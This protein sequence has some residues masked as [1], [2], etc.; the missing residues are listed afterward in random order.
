[1][2]LRT[3]VFPQVMSPKKI[4]FFALIGGLVVLL[5]IA[6]L[7]MGGGDKKPSADSESSGS[8]VKALQ[9]WLLTDETAGYSEIIKGFKN[10]FPQY[11]DTEIQFTKFSSEKEYEDI[12]IDTIANGNSPDVFMLRNNGGDAKFLTKTYEIP[13]SVINV[14]E[15]SKNFNKAFDGLVITEKT[16]DEDGN[17]VTAY[18]LKGVPMGYETLAL[19]YN[20][21]FIRDIPTLWSDLDTEIAANDSNEYAPVGLGLPSRYVPNADAIVEAILLQNNIS[22]YTKLSETAAAAAV[23]GYASF[24]QDAK[25]PVKALEPKM[26]SLF[27]DSVDLFVRGDIGMIVGY[28]STLEKIMEAMKRAGNEKALSEKFV[29]T[30]ALPQVS[31]E[32]DAQKNLVSYRYFA[33]SRF[34]KEPDAAFDFVAY[35]ATKEAQEAYSKAF[36]Y[37]LPAYRALEAGLMDKALNEDI[38]RVRYEHFM[39][40]SVSLEDFDSGLPEKFREGIDSVLANFGAEDLTNAVRKTQEYVSCTYDQFVNRKQLD[41]SCSLVR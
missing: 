31:K 33:V 35:L 19:Y 28:P 32:P 29:R 36:P 16:K 20:F 39:V 2:R 1:M 24:A 37:S 13:N 34:A 22:T 7:F 41:I 21:R 12:L 23:S 5:L 6:S 38:P 18:G 15:F 8:G 10:R 11:K 9:V 25:N 3:N 40:D 26:D 14:D 17:E 4:A 27:L 30:A